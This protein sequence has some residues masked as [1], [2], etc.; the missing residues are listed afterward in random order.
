MS[1]NCCLVYELMLAP[2]PSKT[3]NSSSLLIEQ[4]V[5]T[6]LRLLGPPLP[7]ASGLISSEAIGRAV[8]LHMLDGWCEAPG[9]PA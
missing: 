5:Q 1:E 8:S 4:L 2:W 3:G 7:T 9:S 6:M